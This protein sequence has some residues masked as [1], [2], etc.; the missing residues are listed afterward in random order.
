MAD[1]L[2]E[3]VRD[4]MSEEEFNREIQRNIKEFGGLIDEEAAA[5]LLIDEKGRFEH[6]FDKLSQLEIGKRVNL[7]AR[8]KN[9][10]S[11]RTFSRKSGGTG[12]VA[13]IEISDG[14]GTCRLVLWDRDVELV[15]SGRLKKNEVIR[16][17]NGLVK[18]GR[19]DTEIDIGK[20]GILIIE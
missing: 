2:Y 10:E 19:Y 15:K 13:N 17:L 7:R 3:K 16:I 18:Q 1:K 11:V 8:V 9:I 4:I 20:G 14:S 5:Y 12:E 6:K